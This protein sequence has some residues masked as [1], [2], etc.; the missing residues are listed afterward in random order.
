[1]CTINIIFSY[2]YYCS[3]PSLYDLIIGNFSHGKYGAQVAFTNINYTNLQNHV[4]RDN[5]KA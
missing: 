2:S 1:M 3:V 4:A 5:R